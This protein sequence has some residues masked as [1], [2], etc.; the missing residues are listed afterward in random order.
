MNSFP[1]GRYPSLEP[2]RTALLVLDMQRIWLEPGQCW[3]HSLWPDDHYFYSE[4]S[5]H[6]IPAI[7]QLLATARRKGMEVI[8]VITQ[9]L[10]SDGR[11]CSKEHKLAPIHIG[12]GSDIARPVA[13]VAP[14]N[15]EIVLTKTS[16]AAF[17]AT[18]LDYL[19]QN[20][21]IDCV[22][23]TGIMTD[24][25]IDMT[26]REGIE[27]GYHMT[28]VSDACAAASLERHK[29]T[30]KALSSICSV[31]DSNA[32]SWRLRSLPPTP[33]AAA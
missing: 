16:W 24:Q 10:T 15:D 26:V 14:V 32:V 1:T 2:G 13:A 6:T 31:S 9:S 30:L 12:P 8:H 19:L 21:G 29:S 33:K 3:S 7:Q 20:M 23:V 4:T 18:N 11:E 5:R 28:C 25:C 27:L 17:S 22:L